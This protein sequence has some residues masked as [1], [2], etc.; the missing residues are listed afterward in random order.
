[1]VQ[2]QRALSAYELQSPTMDSFESSEDPGMQLVSS[3]Y[4]VPKEIL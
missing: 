2:T 1:M 3:E 4:S